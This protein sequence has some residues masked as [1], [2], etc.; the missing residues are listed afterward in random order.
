MSPPLLH[1]VLVDLNL[2]ESNNEYN[3]ENSE[4]AL[5]S[6]KDVGVTAL[7]ILNYC[8]LDS[9]SLS[10]E[11]V[12]AAYTT[13][14]SQRSLSQLHADETRDSDLLPLH[15]VAPCQ[16]APRTIERTIPP[17]KILT[18]KQNVLPVRRRH[19]ALRIY[20][21]GAAYTGLAQ[22][23]GSATDASIERAL[24]V[25]LTTARLIPDQRDKTSTV[26]T[27]NDTGNTADGDSGT[28]DECSGFN[29]VKY[30]RC[31][32]TD[33]G[34][35]AAGQVVA[36]Y[37]KSA[38]PLST[39]V[40]D[41]DSSFPPNKNANDGCMSDHYGDISN[42]TLPKNSRDQL[43]VWVPSRAKKVS[44]ST[45]QTQQS[46][47]ITSVTHQESQTKTTT[48]WVRK[49][50]SEYAYDKILNN[51]LPPDIR[52][53]GWCPVTDD[54]SARF[55][56]V[57][58]TYRYFFVP[59][60]NC[61]ISR[62]KDGLNR[63]VGRHDFRNFC[64]MDVEKVYNFERDIH[65]ADIVHVDE[66]TC[67]LLIV[68]QAFLW[69]QIRCIAHIL[70]LIGRG[71][72]EPAIVTE[73]LD[74]SKH[75]G[76]PSYALADERPLVLHDCRYHNLPMRYSVANLWN[77]HCLQRKQ[78]ED[79]CLAAARVKNCLTNLRDVEISSDDLIDFYQVK[80]KLRE[81]KKQGKINSFAS[82]ILSSMNQTDSA[83]P[84]CNL[85]ETIS[86]H[87]A[88]EWLKQK[89]L[90]PEPD[91][92]VEFVYTPLLERSKG[93][94]YEEKVS[95]LQHSTKRRQKYEDNVIKKRKSKEEDAAFYD[96]MTKQGG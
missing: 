19:I 10:E 23:V 3:A 93:T 69:H 49:E 47:H 78:W 46:E 26:S 17:K 33:K 42:D 71:L 16:I 29:S 74:V 58:R 64:K 8:L 22:H 36:L 85:A 72:E 57:S 12:R 37:L 30:S 73:L 13:L 14:H 31:G 39:K 41:P 91:Q 90:Y 34:V 28:S 82:E 5:S 86:W 60:A 1:P 87:D 68:G 70:F 53:L 56:C 89:E 50:L 7:D 15:N 83:L 35:S 51:L 65:S 21:D 38:F 61:H 52:V 84:A 76:K 94:T 81:R 66:N 6:R 80:L 88:L 27:I 40:T 44:T 63:M 75:P 18:G 25:A 43:T 9:K 45:P 24:F 96:H 11:S 55:S 59:R 67:Y 48:P 79:F 62:M 20:Y 92:S 32:R 2:K 77:I 95:A 54:F 4:N